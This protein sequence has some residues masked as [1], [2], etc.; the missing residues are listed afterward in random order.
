M[1]PRVFYRPGCSS[2]AKTKE[3]LS[4]W[5]VTFEA[6]NVAGNPAALEELKRLE[7]VRKLY[8]PTV[9]MMRQIINTE[10]RSIMA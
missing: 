4:S 7:S 1:T 10:A 6:V 2:C 9:A 5:G 8:V 3:L